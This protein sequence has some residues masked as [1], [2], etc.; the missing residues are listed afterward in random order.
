MPCNKE[1]Q[2]KDFLGCLFCVILEMSNEKKGPWL[3]RVYVGDEILPSHMGIIS[4]PII[5]IPIKQPVQWKIRP[6][7]FSLFK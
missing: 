3:F 2:G 6:V 1:V 5:R 4:Q 7:C